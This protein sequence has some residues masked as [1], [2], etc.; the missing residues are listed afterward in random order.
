LSRVFCDLV[1][2][3]E[4]SSLGKTIF[5]FYLL[6]LRILEGSLQYYVTLRVVL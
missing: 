3:V 4:A 5:L 2:N 1:T 6:L